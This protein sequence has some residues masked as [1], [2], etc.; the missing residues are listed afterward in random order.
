MPH[1]LCLAFELWKH[2]YF[3]QLKLLQD[4]P[5]RLCF[6]RY[7]D[8]VVAPDHQFDRILTFLG[9]RYEPAVAVGVGEHH[10]S[11]RDRGRRG[12][13]GGVRVRVHRHL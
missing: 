13:A 7:E 1:D 11:P 9:L 3:L 10:R 2:Y 12:V 5:E 4:L 8:L 6:V